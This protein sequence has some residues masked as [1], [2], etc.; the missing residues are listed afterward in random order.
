MAILNQWLQ[1][2]PAHDTPRELYSLVGVL[3]AS[4]QRE[5]L[6]TT[7]I[8]A[9]PNYVPVQVCYVEL[10]A[11]RNPQVARAQM[12]RLLDQMRQALPRQALTDTRDRVALA[13]LEGQLARALGDVTQASA[14]YAQVLAQEP[15]NI[16]ALTAWG[17]LQV[18]Q[19][20]YEAALDLYNRVLSLKPNDV[21]VRR[22]LAELAATQ[23]NPL[24]A[25]EQ[26]EQIELEQGNA[27]TR[28]RRSAPQ[29]ANS[30][31][32]ATTARLPTP[33]GTLL[34]MATLQAIPWKFAALG[35]V[36]LKP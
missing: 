20:R 4:A 23:G 24:T 27:G 32:P 14:A 10:L 9:D 15:N 29:A 31:K 12:H 35:F 11:Q 7:L 25:L 18:Q 1:S 28:Q 3:P 21:G 13:L 2:R 34:G 16:D 36:T 33:L 5:T 17:G 26:L 6:Y 19:R 30:R 22:S 8:A